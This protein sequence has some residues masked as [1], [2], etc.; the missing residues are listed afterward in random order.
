MK[1]SVQLSRGQD[2]GWKAE[3]DLP[4]G[5]KINHEAQRG[6]KEE[7]SEGPDQTG[8]TDLNERDLSLHPSG[9]Q[10]VPEVSLRRSVR[11]PGGSSSKG[12]SRPDQSDQRTSYQGMAGQP[13]GGQG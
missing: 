8:Q 5:W 4:Q 9:S 13:V 1:F 2:K 10:Q 6:E 11:C 12:F 7:G 3:M